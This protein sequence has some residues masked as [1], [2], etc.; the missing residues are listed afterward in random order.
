MTKIKMKDKYEHSVPEQIPE[1]RVHH[2]LDQG[3]EFVS[4][5]VFEYSTFIDIEI[6]GTLFGTNEESLR[7]RFDGY[8]DRLKKSLE[9]IFKTETGETGLNFS[10]DYKYDKEEEYIKRKRRR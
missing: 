4:K 9:R 2:F 8:I 1:A 6:Q 3:W 5:K 10:I 7:N